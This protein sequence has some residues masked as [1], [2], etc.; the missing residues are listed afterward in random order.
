MDVNLYLF[1]LFMRTPT[2]I[3]PLIGDVGSSSEFVNRHIR[4]LFTIVNVSNNRAFKSTE[5][6]AKYVGT[7]PMVKAFAIHGK[8]QNRPD[9][10]V[11]ACAEFIKQSVAAGRPSKGYVGRNWQEDQRSQF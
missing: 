7:V 11:Y 10:T 9:C 3:T 4:W 5:R 8:R 2:G 1:T 6:V